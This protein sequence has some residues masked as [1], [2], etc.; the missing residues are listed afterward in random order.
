MDKRIIE[1]ERDRLKMIL[2]HIDDDIKMRGGEFAP[3]TRDSVARRIAE[4]DRRL[5][6]ADGA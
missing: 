1:R 3:A 5:K 6:E 4:F 2:R